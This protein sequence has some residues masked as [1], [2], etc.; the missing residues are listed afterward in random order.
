V[1]LSG[2]AAMSAPPCPFKVGDIVWAS[3]D[4]PYSGDCGPVTVTKVYRAP[5]SG[6][7]LKADNGMRFSQ[8]AV[9]ERER[10]G[11]SVSF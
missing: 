5:K 1:F 2:D 11:E 9:V 3:W 6:W 4:E 8:E 7:W 10:D